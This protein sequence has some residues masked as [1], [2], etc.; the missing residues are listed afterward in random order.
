MTGA[1]SAS[2]Y[3]AF[4]A[5]GPG[6]WIEIYGSNLGVGPQEWASSDFNGVNAPTKLAG[7]TVTIGGQS[8]FV[9]YVS[10]GQLDVQVPAG[11]SSGQQNLVVTTA[12]GSSLPFPVT[13]VA[14]KPG[15]L[16]SPAFN[17]GGTQYAVAL[18]SDG[19]TYVLPPGAIPGVASQRA[20]PGDTITLYGIGF[21][22]VN[23]F[24]APG[25]IAQGQSML[26]ESLAVSLGGAQAAIAY[27]GLAPNFVGLY[28]FDVTIPNVA[29]SDAV[30]LTF[31]LGGASGTQKL[32]IAVGN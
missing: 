20:K 29:A 14:A 9:E 31:S 24:V 5:F 26:A 12:S 8:A 25:Q 22:P 7:T 15:L 4:P 3:G 11:V 2:Q 17:I 23:T 19:V 16:A 13:I 6:S 28:Q 30:P 10:A 18:F 21:G 1:V 27:D 32:A